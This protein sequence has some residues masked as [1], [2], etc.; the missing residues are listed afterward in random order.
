M[1]MGH[2]CRAERHASI[3]QTS[4]FPFDPR[5]DLHRRLTGALYM[6]GVHGGISLRGAHEVA[7]E[8]L[9]PYHS[10]FYASLHTSLQEPMDLT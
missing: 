2:E 8:M 1:D 7:D 6:R 5:R 3:P 9:L 4:F 10:S